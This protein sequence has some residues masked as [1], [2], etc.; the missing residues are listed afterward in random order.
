MFIIGK[1]PSGERVVSV[2]G[3]SVLECLW[4]EAHSAPIH[5]RMETIEEPHLDKL[6]TAGMFDVCLGDV[7]RSSYPEATQPILESAEVTSSEPDCVL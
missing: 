6:R 5:T 3:T 1:R 2:T 4:L 7:G